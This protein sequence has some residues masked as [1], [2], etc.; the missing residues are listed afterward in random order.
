M[1]T[2]SA[3]AETMQQT[4]KAS[5]EWTLEAYQ[6]RGNLFFRW[7]Q[8]SPFRAQ[9]GQIRVYENSFPGNPNDRVVAW[10]WDD[11]NAQPWDSGLRWG[12]NWFC[13]RVASVGNPN[14]NNYRYFLQLV[15][16]ET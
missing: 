13:A 7:S 1:A 14:D 6:N 4:V 10:Q 8:N 2:Q 9:Q 16:K 5:F 15:T 11:F 3:D 12:S